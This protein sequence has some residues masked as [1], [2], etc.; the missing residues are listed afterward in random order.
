[1]R[2]FKCEKCDNVIE[3]IEGNNAK[4]ICCGETMKELVANQSDAAAEKH[5][6]A[7]HIEDEVVIVNVGETTHPMEE[8]HYIKYIIAEYSD[9]VIK[10]VFKPGD[11]PESYFDYEKGMKIYAYCNKHGLWLQEL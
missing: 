5:V 1:M 9:S 8:D 6:P 4:M 7:C 11:E 2:M 3:L 10:H